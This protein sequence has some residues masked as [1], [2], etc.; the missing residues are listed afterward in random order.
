MDLIAQIRQWF[1]RETPAVTYEQAHR[2]AMRGAAYLDEVD[3]DWHRRID[4]DTLELANGQSCVLGQLHGVFRNGLTRAR[5]FDL[6]SAPR[7]NL[8]PVRMGFMCRQD[9]PEAAAEQDYRH[10]T[11]AWQ[12]EVRRR[13]KFCPAPARRDV[14]GGAEQRR[15]HTA[16]V[17]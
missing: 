9:V 11:R 13:S 6:S 10:L 3:P 16:P 12:A 1:G 7:A 2:R 5:L 15:D 17:A 14:L 8:S 4:E